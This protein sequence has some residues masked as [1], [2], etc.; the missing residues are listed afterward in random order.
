ML[1]KTFSLTL[2]SAML[3]MQLASAE[4]I[5]LDKATA[6]VP[7]GWVVADDD[8]KFKKDTKAVLNDQGQMVEGVL[9]SDTFLRPTGWKNMIIDCTYEYSSGIVFPYYYGGISFNSQVPVQTYGH[10]RY[11]SGEKVVF[12]ADGTILSG[13]ISDTATFSLQSN[14]YGFV[15]FKDDTRLNFDEQGHILN[16]VLEDDTYLRPLGF[17]NNKN[18]MAGFLEFKGNRTISFT[19]DGF[20]T[21]GELKK[22]MV[23]KQP[24]G[25]TITLPAKKAISFAA[26]GTA[27]V[28]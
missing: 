25:S 21:E 27:K 8:L 10:V 2:L 4:T 22:E 12:S 11:K 3:C 24:N 28:K 26:D 15:T 17:A 6:L 13:V 1:K 5:L 14:K 18:T 7:Q 19:T 9:N 20:V 23:W 16:G